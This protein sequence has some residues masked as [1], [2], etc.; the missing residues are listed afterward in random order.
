[1]EVEEV[2]D[3]PVLDAVDQVAHDAAGEQADAD[4]A[5]GAGGEDV[6]TR[7]PQQRE[8]ARGHRHE[9]EALSRQDPPGGAAIEDFADVEEAGDDRDVLA[10][11]KTGED[12]PFGDLVGDGDGDGDGQDHVSPRDRA[13]IVC[14]SSDSPSRTGT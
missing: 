5:D 3:E 11:P 13:W 8:H 2:D 7:A 12:R 10:Q 6:A 9:H 4:P 1:V 14:G